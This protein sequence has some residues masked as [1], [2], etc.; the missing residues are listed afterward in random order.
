[1]GLGTMEREKEPEALALLGQPLKTMRW[2]ANPCSGRVRTWV[3]I[4]GPTVRA[5]GKL[6][7]RMS[8]PHEDG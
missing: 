7:E 8:R 2:G 1:M 3:Q 6:V 5:L 4:P